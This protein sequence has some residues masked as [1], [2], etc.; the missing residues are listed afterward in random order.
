MVYSLAYLKTRIDLLQGVLTHK[1]PGV[2]GEIDKLVEQAVETPQF[3][4]AC[5]ELLETWKGHDQPPH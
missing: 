2:A 5:R 4:Q 1:Y 3:Q